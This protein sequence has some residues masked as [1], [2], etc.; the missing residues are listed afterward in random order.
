MAKYD[1]FD[2]DHGRAG[3]ADEPIDINYNSYHDGNPIDVIVPV[4]PHESTGSEYVFTAEYFGVKK[5]HEGDTLVW[6]P[7][8]HTGLLKLGVKLRCPHAKN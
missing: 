2:D 5:I 3:V 4:L 1:R 7:N 8:F 6:A